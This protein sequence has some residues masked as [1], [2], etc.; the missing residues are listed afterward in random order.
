MKKQYESPVVN[1]IEFLAEQSLLTVSGFENVEG[2]W[3]I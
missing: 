2:N 3:P 1:V